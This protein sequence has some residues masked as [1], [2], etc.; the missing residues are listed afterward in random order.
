MQKD[1]SGFWDACMY[2]QK[3]YFSSCL[4]LTLATAV[5]LTFFDTVLTSRLPSVKTVKAAVL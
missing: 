3:G 2:V 4:V 5:H 1:S